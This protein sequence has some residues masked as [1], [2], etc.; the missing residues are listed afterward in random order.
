MLKSLS[1]KLNVTLV[2]VTTLMLGA[3]GAWNAHHIRLL[4]TERLEQD[5]NTVLQRLNATLPQA[6]WDFSPS[7]AEKIISAE[8][9]HSSILSLRVTD[10]DG[11]EFAKA[12]DDG[13]NSDTLPK[14]ALQRTQSIAYQ[15]GDK[16]TH[17][18][19]VTLYLTD[20]PIRARV[21]DAILTRF[22]EIIVLDVLLSLA[23]AFSLGQLVMSP[24]K[25]V[26][27]MLNTIARERN[28]TLRIEQHSQ[29]ELGQ[30]A[31]GLNGFLSEINTVIREINHATDN[32]LNVVNE[33]SQSHE[34]LQQEMGRQQFAID[35]LTTALHEIGLTARDVAQNSGETAKLVGVAQRNTS[36]GLKQVQMSTDTTT[37]LT[38]DVGR[39][40]EAIDQLRIKVDAI[41]LVLDVIRDV[42]EQ[43]NLL[44]LNASIEA[45]R[46]GEQ[47]RGFAIVA[48]EVRSLASRTQQSTRQIASSL[49]ELH[50]STEKTVETMRQS[51]PM[52]TESIEN[53]KDAGQSINRILESVN[54]ILERAQQIASAAQQQSSSLTEIDE[55]VANINKVLEH[56]QDVAETTQRLNRDLVATVSNL[57]KLTVR[58]R[59]Q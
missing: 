20:A 2:C 56:T 23:L 38:R 28:L 27:D 39:S 33:T 11:K 36:H 58:F 51:L 57:Q 34:K 50:S 53:A 10:A 18:G 54:L 52:A 3:A 48:D 37:N 24:L 16:A 7:Q 30:L 1:A 32:L 45:A 59:I 12:F 25:R 40:V 9:L 8:L 43:T 6:L 26:L 35:M 31:G 15:D 4:E 14:D 29:D 41:T 55:S 17:V 46:A 42:A 44:A 49:E 5:A 47:G 22:I 19:D 21:R 13:L